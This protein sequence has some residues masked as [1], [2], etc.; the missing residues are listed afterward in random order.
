MPRYIRLL[1][2]V[3]VLDLLFKHALLRYDQLMLYSIGNEQ[4]TI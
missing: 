3:R 1:L 4:Y 2:H